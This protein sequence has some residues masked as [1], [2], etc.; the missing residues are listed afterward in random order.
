MKIID[1]AAWVHVADRK[2]L[3]TLS[4]GKEVYYLPGGRR[5]D[6][7]SYLE[8]VIREVKEEVSVDLDPEHTKLLETFEA[9]AHG[10]EEDVLVRAT[11]FT[12]PYSGVLKPASEKEKIAWLTYDDK[13]KCSPL[14]GLIFDWLKEKNLI[15]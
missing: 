7:E 10:K 6:G 8:T 3:S 9:Q 11:C 12:G 15:D 5:E 2:V 4:K 13:N 14:D 1:T